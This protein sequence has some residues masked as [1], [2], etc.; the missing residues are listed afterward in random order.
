MTLIKEIL[1]CHKNNKRH[2]NNAIFKDEHPILKRKRERWEKKHPPKYKEGEIICFTNHPDTCIKIK[3]VKYNELKEWK[4][5][6]FWYYVFEHNGEN[7]Y[8]KEDEFESVKCEIES[9]NKQC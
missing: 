5:N 8:F 7:Y 1:E 6:L 4:S 3:A 2:N 9:L